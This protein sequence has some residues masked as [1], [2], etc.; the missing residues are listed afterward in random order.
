M[1]I[2]KGSRQDL[3]QVYDLINELALYERAPQEV[4]NT[5]EEM[6]QD[7]FGERPVFEFFVAEEGSRVVGLALY[8][9]AYSTWKGRM[10]YLEDLIVTE[11]Y[12]RTGIGKKLFKAVAQEAQRVKAKRMAWQVLEWNEPAIAFYQ[13]I[14]ASLD[15]EW[16]NCRLTE[17]Q[18]ADFVS[19]GSQA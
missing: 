4:T 11:R 15:G 5:L 14:Q 8:Y 18:I 16:I 1:I 10:L 12:R 7:G 6:A 3:P 19:S 13:T 17:Q 9:T 2:R